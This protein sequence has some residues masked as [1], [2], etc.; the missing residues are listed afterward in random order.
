MPTTTTVVGFYDGG[1]D[2]RIR[3]APPYPGTW[4]YITHSNVDTLNNRNG[5]V[6]VTRATGD[7]HGPVHA[8]GYAFVHADGSPHFSVG[9]VQINGIE[10][11]DAYRWV[12]AYQ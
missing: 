10:Y 8:E 6:V 11:C 1:T 12:C 5:T 2:Y 9:W 4:Q 7:N 3:F